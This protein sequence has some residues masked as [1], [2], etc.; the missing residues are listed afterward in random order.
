YQNGLKQGIW[1][2]RYADGSYV[3]E[4][5]YDKGVCTLGK[6]IEAGS[7]TVRYT[8]S[9]Q[10][11]QFKGG[12]SALSKFLGQN[13]TYPQKAAQMKIQGKVFVNFVIN[14]DGTLEDVFVVQGIGFGCDEEAK[15]VVS[16]TQGR[17]IP[18]IQRGRPVKVRFVLPINFTLN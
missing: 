11:P 13:L 4:E 18:G 14:T 7:D 8:V 9:E 2:G 12:M 6:S 5:H 10:P 3:Y 16:Q 17:W 1:T 15:R